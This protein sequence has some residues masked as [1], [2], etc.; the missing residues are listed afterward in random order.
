MKG[1]TCNH[2]ASSHLFNEKDKHPRYFH[3][4]AGFIAI[5]DG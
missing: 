4:A 3:L 2:A 1:A 5:K